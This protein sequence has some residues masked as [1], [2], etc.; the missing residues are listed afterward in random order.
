MN[1]TVT[2]SGRV[3]FRTEQKGAKKLVRAEDLPERPVGRIPRISRLMALA[4]H[5]DGL[6]ASGAVENYAELARL[7]GV[8]RAR[9][10]QIMN[11]LHLSP[12]IQEQLLFLPRVGPGE[13]EIRLRDLQRVAREVEWGRQGVVAGSIV[14][15]DD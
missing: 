6:I 8:T 5:F 10:S 15:R 3:K 14:R 4:I 9:I 12:A 11:L 1:R 7:G 2:I 13:P